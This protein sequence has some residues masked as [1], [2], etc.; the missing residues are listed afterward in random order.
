MSAGAIA[1]GVSS[2]VALIA[3]SDYNDA[4][5]MCPDN[6]CVTI[7]AYNTT[8]D[9]RKRANMMSFVAGGG[10]ALLGVGVFL[11]LTSKGEAVKVEKVSHVQ[12]LITPDGI[13]LA[14]GG[15]L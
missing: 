3:R 12:P 7:D 11:V 10:V 6:K 8:Q 9:A 5:A 13:G 4:I 2:Y 14:I 15:S 1:I